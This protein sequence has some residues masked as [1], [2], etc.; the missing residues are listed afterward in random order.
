M[1]TIKVCTLLAAVGLVLACVPADSTS[2]TGNNAATNTGNNTG[3]GGNDNSCETDRGCNR[4][5]I[6]EQNACVDGCRRDTDC[7]TVG[8]VCRIDS[9]DIGECI[10]DDRVSCSSN[11]ACQDGEV[12]DAGYCAEI[13]A[14][15]CSSNEQCSFGDGQDA[16]RGICDG[17]VCKVGSYGG[18]AVDDHCAAG[19]RCQAMQDGSQICVTECTQSDQCDGIE[20]CQAMQGICWYN[21]CGS[22][23]ESAIQYC[24]GQTGAE[25]NGMFGETCNGHGEG[26]GFCVRQ[27]YQGR[28]VGLCSA[29]Q[30]G[31]ACTVLGDNTCGE[32]QRCHMIGGWDAN[33]RCGAAGAGGLGETCQPGSF[34]GGEGLDSCAEGHL[35]LPLQQGSGCFQLCDP[36]ATADENDCQ[37]VQNRATSCIAMNQLFQS[38]GA[39]PLGL[40]L[41]QQ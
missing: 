12:C 3:N 25:C 27:P 29:N 10:T 5:E 20:L 1:K 13:T 21:F 2:N 11:S 9:G 22:A 36:S 34:L 33:G 41:P 18:C 40:C 8:Q 37:A 14:I 31:E 28:W 23:E 30:P 17:G 15:T 4:G 24:G 39:S 38:Q 19:D 16:I 7:R 32:G 6:C 26:D 35:C